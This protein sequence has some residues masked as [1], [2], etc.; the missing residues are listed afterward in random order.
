MLHR[1]H[2]AYSSPEVRT[3]TIR[4]LM[5]DTP[6][7]VQNLRWRLVHSYFPTIGTLFG[8]GDPCGVLAGFALILGSP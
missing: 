1:A 8:I 3:E 7:L 2:L 4:V 5:P 6:P